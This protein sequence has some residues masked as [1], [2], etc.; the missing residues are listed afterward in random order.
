MDLLFDVIVTTLKIFGVVVV[1]CLV[2]LPHVLL[3]MWMHN[4]NKRF[5]Y[6]TR[7]KSNEYI[8]KVFL[9]WIGLILWASFFIAIIIQLI[10]RIPPA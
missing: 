9:F 1:L 5:T 8:F 4:L 3:V 2:C 7:W 10:Q 6:S